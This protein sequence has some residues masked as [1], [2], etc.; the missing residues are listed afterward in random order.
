MPNVL[1]MKKTSENEKTSSIKPEEKK[2]S[3]FAKALR[4]S[5]S[6]GKDSSE[7]TKEKSEDV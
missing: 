1:L 7:E 6:K 2:E 3:F 4:A 5:M